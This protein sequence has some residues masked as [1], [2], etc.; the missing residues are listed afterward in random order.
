MIYLPDLDYACYVVQSEDVIRAYETMPT[1]NNTINYRDYYINSSYIYR[2]GTQQ[3]GSYST[4]PTC[5]DTNV[6]TD[7]VF[8]RQD[9]ADIFIVFFIILFISYFIIKKVIRA[10][11]FGPRFS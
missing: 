9:I 2:D 3:F 6:I 8:Y 4:L 7:A 10:F 5:L 1:Y 11:F